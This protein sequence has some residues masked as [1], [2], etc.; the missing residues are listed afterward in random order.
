M[1]SNCFDVDDVK[2]AAAGQ[3]VSIL[4]AAGMP[5]GLLDGRGHPCPKC[6]GTDRFSAFKDTEE[7]G[8]VMCRQCFS[9]GNGDGFA[10]I[11]WFTDWP[12]TESLPFVAEQ[13]GIQPASGVATRQEVDIVAAV[14]RAKRMPLDAFRQ[15]GAE[16]AKRGKKPVARV[17]VYN[18]RGEQHSYFDMTTD[19]KGLFKSGKGSAGMFFP[20]KLPQPGE[21]WLV[22][23]GCKD[24]SA[25]VGLGFNAAGLPRN[26][27]DAKYA[28]LFAGCDVVLIP[29]LDSAGMTGSQKTGGR[30]VAI[31][32]SVKVARPPGEVV[33]SG[34]QDVRDVLAKEGEQAIRNAIGAAKPW[35]PSETDCDDR[36]EVLV[37]FD[38]AAVT[39][40]VLKF[41]GKLGS[42]TPW[43]NPDEAERATI[44]QRGGV[45]V[46]IVND[47]RSLCRKPFLE[48][49]RYR[50]RLSENGLRRP[51]SWSKRLIRRMARCL[52]R[53]V[54]VNG[55]SRRL[56]IAA[57]TMGASDL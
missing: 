27:M 5:A 20:G 47:S 10:T 48:F 1:M 19:G 22:V 53:S 8:G 42:E 18:E 30:L 25:L 40:E 35:E 26:E 43:L 28:G 13:V 50:N 41:L 33:K 23:E 24:G 56:I 14:A 44:Y 38:E 7:T 54:R 4:A 9:K 37:T 21:T 32:T 17:P 52:S 45:L 12:F 39:S 49:D 34:G 31:A 11:Q 3:W 55:W 46:Q 6:G 36:P 51:F 2:R 29:D 57:I 16:A 15:F